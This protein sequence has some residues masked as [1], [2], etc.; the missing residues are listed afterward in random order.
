MYLIKVFNEIL[1]IN[2]DKTE[3]LIVGQRNNNYGLEQQIELEG[4]I[5]RRVSQFEYLGSIMKLRQRCSQE[6]N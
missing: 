3:Y 6:Y 2:D 4:H 1:I 5:F